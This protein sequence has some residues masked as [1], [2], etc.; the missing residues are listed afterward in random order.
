MDISQ[1][2]SKITEAY[3]VE[4]LNKISLVLIQLFKNKQI[5]NLRKIVEIVRESIDIEINSDG[6]GFSKLMMLYHPDRREF[7]LKELENI[8][9][10]NDLDALLNYAHILYLDRID[11]LA[12]NIESQED[13]D[14]S[15]VYEWDFET[16][17]FSI[18]ME[19]GKI[20]NSFNSH[21]FSNSEN[22]YTFYE[23]IK[24][25]MY[26]TTEIEFPSYYLEDIDE[27]ELSEAGISELEGVEF[28][29]HTISLDLSE[30]FISDLSYLWD[31]RMLTELNLSYNQICIIDTLSNLQNLQILL[32]S[33]N[34]I[35]D[36]SA[37]FNLSKLKFVDLSGND[38]DEKQINELRDSGVQVRFDE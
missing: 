4:N 15:P 30:N 17:G 5:E 21:N 11:E 2:Y 12:L 26:G 9:Q 18:Y 29:V 24:M 38:I 16:N 6:K 36:I 20:D 8:F 28:C 22:G 25:R 35:N 13:I 37:L 10:N 31:L 27:L 32:L 23:A 7:H 33:H 14:F 3:Q 19:E 34:Q 1:L